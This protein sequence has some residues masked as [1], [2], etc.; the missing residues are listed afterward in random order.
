[1]SPPSLRTVEATAVEI[2]GPQGVLTLVSIYVRPVYNPF[3]TLDLE[4]LLTLGNPIVLAGDYN[5][6]HRQWNCRGANRQGT[7]LLKFAKYVGL[8]IRAPEDPTHLSQG[9]GSIIDL[10]VTRNFPYICSL[11]TLPD[12]SSD[13]FPVL[14]DTRFELPRNQG[15]FRPNW[16]KFTATLVREPFVA[17]FPEDQADL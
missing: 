4:S 17:P 16:E 7:N 1:M 11:R 10:A 13:H 15:F 5:A 9:G 14:L 3:F 8:E 6:H 2:T 12:L